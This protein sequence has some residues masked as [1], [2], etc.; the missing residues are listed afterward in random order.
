M[1]DG[2]N[3]Q[4]ISRAESFEDLRK[5]LHLDEE[6]DSGVSL[7]DELIH[8]GKNKSPETKAAIDNIYKLLA[9]DEDE[10][11]TPIKVSSP[12]RRI[13]N[14]DFSSRQ[15]NNAPVSKDEKKAKKEEDLEK[16]LSEKEAEYSK[17]R[18]AKLLE[19]EAKK[20]EKA[21][22]KQ[23]KKN[24]KLEKKKGVRKSDSAEKLNSI[25]SAENAPVIS[26]SSAAAEDIKL[27]SAGILE[28][29][30]ALE[31]ADNEDVNNISMYEFDR[32]A[33]FKERKGLNK[34]LYN[35]FPNKRDPLKEKLRKTVS[36]LSVLTIVGCACFFGS[37]YLQ[38]QK[39]VRQ[40]SE[41]QR[42]IVEPENEGQVQ[43]EWDK[44]KAEYPDVEFPGGMNVKYARLYALNPE[45][46]AWLSIPNT[47]I[48]V[49]VVKAENNEKYLKQDFYGQYSRYGCPFMDFR[50][51]IRNLSM[52]TIIYGHHMKDGLMFAELASY[53]K[54]EGFENA[55]VISLSTLYGD[56]NFKIYAVFISNSKPEDDNGYLFNFI[57]NHLTSD[58]AFMSYIQAV[59]ERKLY[60]T[61]VDIKP[62]DK[63]LT[64]S[65]CT[66]E[67]DDARLV[68]LA[69]MVR[70][71]E[72]PTSH[73]SVKINEKP[74]F[75][76]KWYE[77]KKQDNPFE[78]ADRWYPS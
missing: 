68:V 70:P 64:L 17:K 7:Y 49:Q 73:G 40:T 63:L 69:R 26:R 20:E 16:K 30:T 65:T 75:P 60:D 72:S 71:G 35:T 45:F 66:Y 47:Q 48:N 5:Q 28:I 37:L 10:S 54:P 52:N 18:S 78:D 43:S 21:A 23:R 67:F 9:D 39:N 27:D 58:E 74:R 15:G 53:Q 76:A 29:E 42:Y 33:D 12:S 41:L 14:E 24:M 19:K 13:I 50:D 46:V 25:A 56:Y 4:N 11:E 61:G 59:D 62:G 55:P 36:I 32:T 2:E 77:T 34:F 38:K 3:K 57:F 51:N 44:I 22:A 1:T 6:S 8:D 31:A